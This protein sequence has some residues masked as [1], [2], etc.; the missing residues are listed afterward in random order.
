MTSDQS[1]Q[2]PQQNLTHV[3]SAGD[4]G[5]ASVMR[6]YLEHHGIDVLISGENSRSVLGMVGGFV[7]LRIMVPTPQAE[8]AKELLVEYEQGSAEEPPEH[9]GPFRDELDE[10]DEQ[11]DG[12]KDDASRTRAK[13]TALGVALVFPFG[14][15]HFVTGAI[16]RGFLLGGVAMYSLGRGFENHAFL[17]LFAA[18][19]AVDIYGSQM[20]V[21]QGRRKSQETT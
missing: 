1:R 4:N 19:A 18:A 9:R 16:L 11:S 20:R 17:G 3:A 14:G 8:E 15:G 5:E 2:P 21:A 13:R 6:S 10:E 7:E 12:W